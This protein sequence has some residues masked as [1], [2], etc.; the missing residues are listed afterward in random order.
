[1]I[2]A[3]SPLNYGSHG[4]SRALHIILLGLAIIYYTL[5]TVDE[6]I[7]YDRKCSEI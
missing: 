5:W 2:S 4:V 6:Y 3:L 7:Q 1:M